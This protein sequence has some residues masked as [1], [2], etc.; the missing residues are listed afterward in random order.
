MHK[1]MGFTSIGIEITDGPLEWAAFE[2]WLG[3]LLTKTTQTVVAA[4]G[5]KAAPS[6]P[7]SASPSIDGV[8]ASTPATAL[9][10]AEDPASLP[11]ST[12][13]Q[14][15]QQQQVIVRMKG[16]VYVTKKTPYRR[17]TIVQKRV[18]LQ[19]IYGHLEMNEEDLPPSLPSSPSLPP[20]LPPCS[21]LVLIGRF[22]DA[23]ALKKEMERGL[24]ECLAPGWY[25]KR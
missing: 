25:S 18:V 4:P 21:K 9:A 15:Q 7:P 1:K 5:G 6:L 23:E 24:L 17:A 13:Q 14:Q 12:Q 3:T 19:G 10:P 20:S 22:V 16:I 2:Q 11:P 8:A